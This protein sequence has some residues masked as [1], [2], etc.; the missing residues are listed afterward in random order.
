MKRVIHALGGG[1]A[2]IEERTL[3]GLRRRRILRFIP[4]PHHEGI[5]IAALAE[6]VTING[7]PLPE[8]TAMVATP[9][10]KVSLPGGKAY[11]TVQP[12]E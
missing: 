12:R 5:I 10:D 11:F 9:G 4:D 2:E 3:L 8:R 1:E 7:I 6:G